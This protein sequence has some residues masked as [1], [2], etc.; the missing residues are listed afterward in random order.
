MHKR[1]IEEIQKILATTEEPGLYANFLHLLEEKEYHAALLEG[2]KNARSEDKAL[3]EMIGVLLWYAPRLNIDI[4]VE[5]VD[6]TTPVAYAMRNNNY[7]LHYYLTTKSDAKLSTEQQVGWLLRISLAHA[8]LQRGYTREFNLAMQT[9]NAKFNALPAKS[10][11]SSDEENAKFDKPRILCILMII[12]YLQTYH[13]DLGNT[14][15]LTG[16]YSPFELEVLQLQRT[17]WIR[18][19]VSKLSIIVAN[20]SGSLRKDYV[21]LLKDIDWITL[22]QLGGI[23][24]EQEADRKFALNIGEMDQDTGFKSQMDIEAANRFMREYGETEELVEHAALDIIRELTDLNKFFKIIY[25]DLIYTTKTTDVE[26][27][28][29]PITRI[30]TRHFNEKQFIVELLH[31]LSYKYS[32]T[33]INAPSKDTIISTQYQITDEHFD[34]QMGKHAFLRRIQRL[35]EIFTGKNTNFTEF[36]KSIDYQAVIGLRD[37]IVHQ[38]E[39]HN[40]YYIDALLANPIKLKAIFD[41]DL[42]ELMNKIAL[43][44]NLRDTR[45]G[46]YGGNTA[47]Y[48]SRVLATELKRY[49]PEPE[50]VIE[51]TERRVSKEE[52][53]Q[54]I[55]L[56][57]KAL[58]I[59]VVKEA[60]QTP[61]DLKQRCIKAMDGSGDVLSTRERGQSF[62]PF[63]KLRKTENESIYTRLIEILTKTSA[64]PSTTEKEREEERKKLQKA[65]Q[66]RR[67][68]KEM[69]LVGLTT[70]RSL[71]KEINET[72]VVIDNCLTPLKRIDAVISALENMKAF[73]AE[74]G[75]L[76]DGPKHKTMRNWDKHQQRTGKK[77]LVS[78]LL[79]NRVLNDALEYNAGQALQFLDKIREY[80]EASFCQ[81]LHQ[82]Y[83]GFR[84]L[85]NYIEHGHPLIK[86]YDDNL[87]TD[88]QN[89]GRRQKIIAPV[90]IKMI[91]ELLP[92]CRQIKQNIER[93]KAKRDTAVSIP[94]V[95]SSI[96]APDHLRSS[97]G[98]LPPLVKQSFFAKKKETTTTTPIDSLKLDL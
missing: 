81:H 60:V 35:G 90:L 32:S 34:T 6:G 16:T 29:L 15:F 84:T 24:K 47:D 43:F 78:L 74:V 23:I 25:K 31:L 82:G 20:L 3:T 11:I 13:S 97:T 42:P 4:N 45:Y 28:A 51:T 58:N 85:R 93:G 50:I 40:K 21:K 52:E 27:I 69:S 61:E 94:K 91:F 2:C 88:S 49:Q 72:P 89:L 19:Y 56:F 22:E 36:D 66:E 54:F 9:I 98:V 53:D 63:A 12:N 73:L 67:L 59:D 71:V 70:V 8:K 14:S 44:I 7:T 57:E 55:D 41:V 33:T 76:T 38:D 1:M 95:V 83:E 46:Y 5:D 96:D 48:W 30:I 79:S 10:S 17:A 68:K 86:S 18:D 77:D 39:S 64:K 87:N 37:I 75:Y 92:D 62:A 65:A 26:E 80:R